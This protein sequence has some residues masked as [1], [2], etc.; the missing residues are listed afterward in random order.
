[1][2]TQRF[3]HARLGALI[4]LLFLL[5]ACTV[6]AAPP[7]PPAA[8]DPDA[9][10]TVVATYSILGDLVANVGGEHVDVVTL[11]GPDGERPHL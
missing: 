8:S 6:P 4:A 3:T 5:T 7:A 11:V 10:L 9:P 2:Q 1:M